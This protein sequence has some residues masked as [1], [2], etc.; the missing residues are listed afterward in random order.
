MYEAY[1]KCFLFNGAL[2]IIGPQY[3]GFEINE[4]DPGALFAVAI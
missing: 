2:M 1:T 3:L 4:K